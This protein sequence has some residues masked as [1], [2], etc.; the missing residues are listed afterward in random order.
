[1]TFSF[2]PLAK[3]H[4]RTSFR[5]GQQLLDDW[6][7]KQAGQ[8]ERRNIA[9]VFV[10]LDDESRVAGFY[11]LSAFTLEIDKVPEPLAKKLPRYDKIPAALI[12]RLARDEHY[13]GQGVG[14]LLMAD[15][16]TRILTAAQGLAVYAI[17]VDAK[18][19]AASNFYQSFGFTPFPNHPDRLFMLTSTAASAFS[20]L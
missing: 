18:D 10:A 1:M 13:R 16:F 4:D 12:G 8:E 3:S 5:C 19:E 7:R 17:V 20:K 6:F 2:A 14:E 9:R 15:A 11:S